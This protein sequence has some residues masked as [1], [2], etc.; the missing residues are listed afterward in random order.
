MASLIRSRLDDRS[1][2]KKRRVSKEDPLLSV[3]GLYKGPVRLGK[4]IDQDLY[5][6]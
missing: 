2:G 5:G 3:A 4:N 1:P 6:I